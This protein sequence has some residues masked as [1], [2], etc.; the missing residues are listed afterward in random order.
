MKSIAKYILVFM[1]AA[2]SC[3]CS[4]DRDL[5]EVNFGSDGLIIDYGEVFARGDERYIVRDDGI[6][7]RVESNIMQNGALQNGDRVI[8]NYVIL[9]DRIDDFLIDAPKGGYDI[10]LNNAIVIPCKDVLRSSDMDEKTLNSLK[11]DPVSVKEV[12]IGIHH[13]DLQIDYYRSE[14]TTHTF[15]LL[16]VE[17]EYDGS[18]VLYLAHDAVADS[19]VG[20]TTSLARGVRISFDVS[21]VQT[22]RHRQIKLIW[23]NLNGLQNFSSGVLGAAVE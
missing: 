18:L 15:D 21:G 5:A 16:G 2:V 4:E 7:L 22:D 1:A 12:H 10:R 20:N 13:I 6:V 17:S 11:Y 14:N 8:V 19:S 9:G 23:T 3:A